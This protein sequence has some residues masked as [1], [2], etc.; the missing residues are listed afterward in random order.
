MVETNEEVGVHTAPNRGQVHGFCWII[1]GYSNDCNNMKFSTHDCLGYWSPCCKFSGMLLI[2][3]L[4]D[5]LTCCKFSGMLL[6]VRLLDDLTCCK[7]SGMLLI[8]RLLDDLT[9]MMSPTL[10]EFL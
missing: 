3:R 8:V 7:F 10:F 1:C 4:L 5:D 9:E 6:I 2:V